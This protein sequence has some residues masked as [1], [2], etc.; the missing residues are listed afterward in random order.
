MINKIN[1]RMKRILYIFLSLQFIVVLNS[2][3]FAEVVV[4]QSPTVILS[5]V[6]DGD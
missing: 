5:G 4:A 2:S 3:A 1:F 6:V